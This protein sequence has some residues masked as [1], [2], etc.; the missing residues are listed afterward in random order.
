MTVE[1][2]VRQSQHVLPGEV[3]VDVRDSVVDLTSLINPRAEESDDCT[4][5]ARELRPGAK[6]LIAESTIGVLAA[7]QILDAFVNRFL[8]HVYAGVPRGPQ[9]HHFA[10]GHRNVSIVGNGFVSPAPFIILSVDDE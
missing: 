10:N 8:R 6:K 3:A 2:I 1:V 7:L 4:C 5:G 9:R